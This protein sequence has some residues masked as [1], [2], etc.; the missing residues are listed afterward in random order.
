[1]AQHSSLQYYRQIFP[2]TLVKISFFKG[3]I[4]TQ[5]YQTAIPT[6]MKK[7]RFMFYLNIFEM[8]PYRSTAADDGRLLQVSWWL[9]IITDRYKA[10]RNLP[11]NRIACPQYCKRR[12]QKRIWMCKFRTSNE[13]NPPI[14][15]LARPRRKTFSLFWCVSQ[16]HHFR[17]DLCVLMGESHL[18]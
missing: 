3:Y 10:N 2:S 13:Q 4:P 12:L 5:V 17:Q 15:I 9:E 1:M 16:T 11:I 6:L 18:L 8:L 14:Q 7:C